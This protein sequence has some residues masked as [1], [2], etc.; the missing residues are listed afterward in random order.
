MLTPRVKGT[1]KAVLEDIFDNP[2]TYVVSKY[3][4]IQAEKFFLKQREL[5]FN[6]R[7]LISKAFIFYLFWYLYAHAR[8]LKF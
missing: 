3:H 1:G 8:E 7:E 4:S 6:F 5:E 2:P